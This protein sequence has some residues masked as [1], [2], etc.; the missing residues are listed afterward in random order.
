MYGVNVAYCE[1][2]GENGSTYRGRYH[3]LQPSVDGRK[4][5][6]VLKFS[7]SPDGVPSQP[8]QD[9]SLVRQGDVGE[10]LL[11]T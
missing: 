8:D 11:Y 3:L 2:L 5:P 10:L 1:T 6:W 4:H 9:V 7:R